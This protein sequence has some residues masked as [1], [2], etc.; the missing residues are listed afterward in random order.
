MTIK[1]R[2]LIARWRKQRNKPASGDFNLLELSKPNRKLRDVIHWPILTALILVHGALLFYL[3]GILRIPQPNVTNNLTKTIP[4]K[5]ASLKAS[6]ALAKGDRQDIQPVDVEV[7]RSTGIQQAPIERCD[8]DPSQK[9]RTAIR[10]DLKP[11]CLS[12]EILADVSK[13]LDEEIKTSLSIEAPPVY[14]DA[15]PEDA[16]LNSASARSFMKLNKAKSISSLLPSDPAAAHSKAKEQ[17]KRE[18]APPSQTAERAFYDNIDSSAQ[19]WPED[20]AL[21]PRAPGAD[22]A[23]RVHANLQDEKSFAGALMPSTSSLP[24]APVPPRRTSVADEIGPQRYASLNRDDRY[25]ASGSSSSDVSATNAYRAKVRAHLAGHKPNGG[26]G[27]GLVVVRFTL[28]PSGQVMAA[29][30]I[31]SSGQESLDDSV[32]STVYLSAPFPEAPGSVKPSQL[33]F[34]IPFRFE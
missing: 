22:T 3:T 21:F 28:S 12:P 34:A 16:A 19:I 11:R 2:A 14:S 15:L 13:A 4:V 30:I 32:L 25:E 18:A 27:E 8:T 31:R 24:S 10:N 17:V 9:D 23:P 5:L 6:E 33:R 29:R 20:A 26:F 7:A 1:R